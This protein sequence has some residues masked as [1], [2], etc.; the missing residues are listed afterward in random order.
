MNRDAASSFAFDDPGHT[1]IA[2][3]TAPF[4]NQAPSVHSPGEMHDRCLVAARDAPDVIEQPH[5]E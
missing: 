5:F 4:Q 3:D 1:A 2:L